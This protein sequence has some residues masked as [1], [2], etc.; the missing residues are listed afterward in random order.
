VIGEVRLPHGLQFRS[1]TVGGL[2]GLDFDPVKQVWY[3]LSDD[4]SNLQPARFYTLRMQVARDGLG[5]P[6]LVDAVALR[7][8][9]GAVYP[10]Q[11]QGGVGPDPEAMRFRPRTGTLLW[12]D[13]GDIRRG[14]D[15]ALREITLE[16]GHLREFTLPPMFNAGQANAGPRH[17]LTFEGMALLPDDSGV[18]V[19]MESA[20]VQDGPVPTFGRPGGPCRLTLFDMAG[21][22]PVRQLAYMPDAIPAAPIPARAFADNGVSEILMID[23]FRMLVL[24]RAYMA[25]VGNSLRL[26]E[27]DTRAGTNTLGMTTLAEGMYQ[28]SPKKLVLDFAASGLGRL[29]NTEA[30]AWG[31]V[32]PGGRRTLVLASDDNFNPGQITQFAGFEYQEEE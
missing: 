23:A 21:G 28:A 5:T 26:Y 6:E 14:Q 22:Q 9:D 7:R 8:Q 18:W 30:M 11:K 15:P 16:G 27:I 19:A 3:A 10:G 24:E 12:A 4:G 29:D 32:L 25:G 31:P 13:E 20:L 17:N 1:T 2:S